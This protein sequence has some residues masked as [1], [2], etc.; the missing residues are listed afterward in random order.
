MILKKQK[1]LTTR[2]KEKIVKVFKKGSIIL[3]IK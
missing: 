1:N 3:A 2:K